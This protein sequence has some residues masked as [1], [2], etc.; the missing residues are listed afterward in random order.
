MLV[1]V[2]G[3][4]LPRC[5]LPVAAAGSLGVSG[6]WARRDYFEPLGHLDRRGHLGC[7]AIWNAGAIWVVGP[8]GSPGLF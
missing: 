3:S 5:S 1:A 7:E 2:G 4:D 6:F 8:F